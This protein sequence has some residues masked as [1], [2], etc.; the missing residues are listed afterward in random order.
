MWTGKIT[1]GF[2]IL[3]AAGCGARTTVGLDRDGGSTTPPRDAGFVRDGGTLPDAG[4][5][6]PEKHRPE[7]IDCDMTR[8]SPQVVPSGNP[9]DQCA[10]HDDCTD[11]DN[12]RCLQMRFGYVCTYDECFVDSDCASNVCQCNGGFGSDANICMRQGNCLV[13]ADCGPGNFCSPTFGDCGSY[14]GTVGYYCHT[15]QD[16][17]VNDSDCPGAGWYCRYDRVGERWS[18]SDAQCAG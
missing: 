5:E 11:G 2:L 1:L 12:G 10:A 4:V 18:C 13:D 8:P 3:A 6:A 7:R 14:L 16:E 9:E 15:E 17:C